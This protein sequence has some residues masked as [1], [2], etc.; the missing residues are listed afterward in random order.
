VVERLSWGYWAQIASLPMN[1]TSY[2]NTGLTA[3]TSYTYRVS[4]TNSSG[5]IFYG[6]TVS[7]TT[8]SAAPT[9][10]VAPSGLAASVISSSQINLTRV[11]ARPTKRLHA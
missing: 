6:P 1:Y 11:D 9:L 2:S 4:V 7:A 10:P 8:Q 3:S 5:S